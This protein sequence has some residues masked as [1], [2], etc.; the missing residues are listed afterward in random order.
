LAPELA[1]AFERR[2]GALVSGRGEN[3]EF[4]VAEKNV[5]ELLRQALDAGA[6]VR[7]LAP[8]RV[9]LESIFLSAVE[10]EAREA[11][12]EGRP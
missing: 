2:Y 10:Q 3:L 6:E 5:G 7:A 8:H 12:G 9:S 4:R 1:E 11:K